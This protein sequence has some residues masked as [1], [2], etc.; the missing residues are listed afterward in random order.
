MK[1]VKYSVPAMMCG[2]CVRTIESEVGELKGVASVKAMLDSKSVEVSF[3]A[4]ATEEMIVAT[5]KEINYPP[6]TGK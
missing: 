6:E 4:P 3:D 5:L 1:T 2:H